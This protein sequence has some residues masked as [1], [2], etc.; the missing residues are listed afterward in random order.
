MK[1][2]V[3]KIVVRPLITEKGTHQ[4]SANNAYAFAV[5]PEANKVQIK[6]AIQEIYGV[7]VLGV[8]TSNRRGKPRRAGLRWGRTKHWK[9]AVVV[10]HADDH[11]DLF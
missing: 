6:R 7:R 2:Q 10:L 9:K 1:D 11:I 4:S 8:R 5:L 3:Y